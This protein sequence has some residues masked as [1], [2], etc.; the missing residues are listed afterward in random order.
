M[1]TK[2]YIICVL[3]LCGTIIFSCRSTRHD[4]SLPAFS[5]VDQTNIVSVPSDS[6]HPVFD[7]LIR[8]SAVIKFFQDRNGL[9]VWVND[10]KLTRQGDS[11]IRFL[12]RINYYGLPHQRYHLNEIAIGLNHEYKTDL[13]KVEVLLTDAFFTLSHDIKLGLQIGTS[14]DELESTTVLDS[15]TRYGEVTQWLKHRE[16]EHVGYHLLK[17]ALGILLDSLSSETNLDSMKIGYKI[18]LI[19]INIE[20]WRNERDVFSGRYMFINIP[21]FT[22]RVIDR[23]DSLLTSRIIVGDVKH[24]TPEFS[25]IIDCFTVY[26][27]WHVPRAIAVEEYLPVIQRD[28]SFVTRNNLEI[29]DPKGVILNPAD[30]P[31]KSFTRNHFPVSLRQREG[32]E[33]ALGL[34]KFH[35]DN[36]Y[37]IYVHDTNAKKLFNNTSRA[38]SHGCIRMEKAEELAHYLATGVVGR[39]SKL[40]EK[41]LIEKRRILVNVSRPLPIY[42]RYFTAEVIGD[43]LIFYKDIYGKDRELLDVLFAARTINAL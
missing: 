39:K 4:L 12:Q 22:L 16:P 35:F 1:Q 9:P 6:T 37:S 41:S 34:F 32:S 31:W 3:A 26:P 40:V 13:L 43:E 19:N 14:S 24:P 38:L 8:R 36:P 5:E 11:L 17:H 42:L 28:T 30:V 33:N 15:V 29:L 10:G 20:R 18:D 21:S 25:S 7:S 2:I 27:Y 23:A